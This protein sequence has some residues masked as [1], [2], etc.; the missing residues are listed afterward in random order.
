MKIA[1]LARRTGF[2]KHALRYYERIGL[3]PRVTRDGARHRDYDP[4]IVAWLGFLR[5]LKTTGMPVRE[6]RRY[7]ALRSGGPET[8]AARRAMLEAH[9]CRVHTDIAELQACLVILDT[10]IAGY[11]GDSQGMTDHDVSNDRDGDPIRAGLAKPRGD[12][13]ARG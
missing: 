4:S 3:L 1:E 6:M 5:R 9:R 7:A 13:R 2:S 11:A 8:I 10:K 12:R